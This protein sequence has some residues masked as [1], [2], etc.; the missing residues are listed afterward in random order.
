MSKFRLS[1]VV[2]ALVL[3]S[4]GAQGEEKGPFGGF[5]HD[6]SEPIEITSDTLE[7]RQSEQ[8]AIFSGDVIAGQG[9]LRLT[10]D[11][12]DVFYSEQED[13][14]ATAETESAA[15]ADTGAIERLIATGNVF[16][17]NG[18]E[19][20]QGKTGTYDVTT[21]I[22]TMEGSVVLTQGG[23]AISGNN[24]EIDLNTGVG[25]VLGGSTGRVKSVFTPSSKPQEN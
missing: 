10:S 3:S 24:L 9:T 17:S 7:V 23:N 4:A 5:K 13:D 16:L 25:K 11:K 6:N 14:G 21:G 20:A 15:D 1:S 22:V 12:L 18:T 8:L 19:T 2:L